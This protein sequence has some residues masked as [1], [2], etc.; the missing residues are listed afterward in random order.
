MN[1]PEKCRVSVFSKYGD[2]ILCVE[3]AEVLPRDEYN[4]WIQGKKEDGKKV[5]ILPGNGQAVMLEE[6]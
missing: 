2:V 5:S 4:S 1:I 6:I 3:L